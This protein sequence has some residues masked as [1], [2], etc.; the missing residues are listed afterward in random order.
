MI[1]NK[2]RGAIFTAILLLSLAFVPAVMAEPTTIPTGM[3][4][5]KV[6]VQSATGVLGENLCDGLT[7]ALWALDQVVNDNRISQAENALAVGANHFRNNQISA[8]CTDLLS[9]VRTSTT[10]LTYWGSNLASWLYNK[11]LD[12][13]NAA[14]SFLHQQG[15]L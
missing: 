11:L 10:L 6:I 2:T 7:A 14:K 3:S 12:A 13:I 15:Y 9:G 5:D 8:G 4:N 1:E